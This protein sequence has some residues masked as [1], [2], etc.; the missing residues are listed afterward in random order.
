MPPY[1]IITLR[2]PVQ[3]AELIKK[4][5][6]KDNRSVNQW[7]KLQLVNAAKNQK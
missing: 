4:A 7:A 6:D 3:E 1:K 5:A 2:V